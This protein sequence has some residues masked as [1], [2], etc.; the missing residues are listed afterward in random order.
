[1]KSGNV[2]AQ[3]YGATYKRI[4]KA[5]FAAI[6]YSFADRYRDESTYA[7]T[8]ALDSFYREWEILHQN[9]IIPQKPVKERA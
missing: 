1:M 3:Q 5:V 2:Y 4:P 7:E 8:Q 9:G 6:A